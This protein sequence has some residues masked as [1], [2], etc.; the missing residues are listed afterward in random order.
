MYDLVRVLQTWQHYL[1][2]KEFVIHSGHE[3]LKYLKEQGK[4]NKRHV[5]WVELLKKILYAIKHKKG[6]GNIVFGAL[7]RR[8]VLLSTLKTKIFGLETLREMYLHDAE[9]FEIYTA[10]EKVSQNGYYTH[11]DYLF[12]E[13]RL[14][15][16]KCSIRDLLVKETHEGGLM[17]HLRVQKTLE[18]LH[19]HFY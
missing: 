14:C 12:K 5:K 7:S 11:N 10:C 13:K 19:E 18:T 8:H 6:K 2:S 16:C 4:L 3:S 9:F 17:R 15:V 1:R